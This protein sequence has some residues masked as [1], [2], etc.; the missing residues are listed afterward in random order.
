MCTANMHGE[1]QLLHFVQ[2]YAP[3][4]LR[5]DLLGFWGRHPNARFSSRAVCCALDCNKR[6]AEL[7]LKELVDAG[8]LDACVENGMRFYCLT[9]QAAMRDPVTELGSLGWDGLRSVK[10][11][12][13]PQTEVA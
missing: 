13:R 6:D 9:T 11:H 2:E 8:I 12:L 7:A 3:D 5:L 4:R 1:E 10:R